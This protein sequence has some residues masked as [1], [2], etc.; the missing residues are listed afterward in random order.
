MNPGVLIKNLRF[1]VCLANHLR[2]HVN[3]VKGDFFREILEKSE[4]KILIHLSSQF[5]LGEKG[6]L[7]F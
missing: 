4:C 7:F 2:K 5:F 6:C 3:Y 1:E